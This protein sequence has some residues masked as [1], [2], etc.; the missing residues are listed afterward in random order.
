MSG[1][2]WRDRVRGQD[3]EPGFVPGLQDGKANRLPTFG[4]A[5]HTSGREIFQKSEGACG[6]S[7]LQ[8]AFRLTA[9]RL[10]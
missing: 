2:L 3:H 5:I 4:G 10:T 7:D 1:V 9:L 8:M 6:F